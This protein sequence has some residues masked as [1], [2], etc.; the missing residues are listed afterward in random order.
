MSTVDVGGQA[1]ILDLDASEYQHHEFDYRVN[2]Q[3]SLIERGMAVDN[4]MHNTSVPSYAETPET[5]SGTPFQSH[6]SPI[7]QIWGMGDPYGFGLNPHNDGLAEPYAGLSGDS[8]AS[9][10]LEFSVNN[11]LDPSSD[12]DDKGKHESSHVRKSKSFRKLYRNVQS[13]TSLVL[14]KLA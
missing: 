6:V 10:D 7:P 1:R 4:I 2:T 11:N 3:A 9:S 14:W 12:I 8:S 13:E 5:N